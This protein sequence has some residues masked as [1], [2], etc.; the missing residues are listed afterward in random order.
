ML[1]SRR[2]VTM[3]GDVFRDEWSLAFDGTD[4]YINFGN[5]LNLGTGDFSISIWAKAPSDWNNT[6]MLIKKQDTNNRYMLWVDTNNPP[7]LAFIGKIGGATTISYVGNTTINLDNLINQWVHFT[8]SCDRSGDIVGYIN[9]VLDDADTPSDATPDIDNTGNLHI[10]KYDSSYYDQ[11][12]S[13]IAYYDKA[14]SANEVK[15]IYNG[16]EPFN[17]KDSAFSGNLTAWWRM[18]DGLENASG[19]TIYDMSSN[20]NNGTMTNMDAVDFEGDTP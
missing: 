20:S 14:L 5:V 10:G 4:D 15:T 1:P 19:T 6:R 3:S 11:S 8:I 16:R 9:G 17:H 7:R 13:E 18:G 12:I 2:L